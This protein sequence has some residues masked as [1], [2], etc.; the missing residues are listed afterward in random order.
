MDIFEQWKKIEEEKFNHSPIKKEEIMEA[1][2]QKST[3]TMETLKVRL[4]YKMVWVLFFIICFTALLISQIEILPLALILGTAIAFYIAGF[5][6]LRKYYLSM[7][8][9][10]SDTS[11]LELMKENL[12]LIKKALRFES[13]IMIPL[14]PFMFLGGVTTPRLLE[15]D[16]LAQILSEPKFLIAI[17]LGA[18]IATPIAK[19]LGDRA[20]KYAYGEYISKLEGN[21]E[22]MENL[23]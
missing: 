19:I 23:K 3:G 18:L 15:G 17:V 20:N 9:D 2:Y 10:R 5:L 1:I 11:T 8:T 14:V 16:T 13:Q 22:E 7:G 21:I 6:G 12:Q 4:K